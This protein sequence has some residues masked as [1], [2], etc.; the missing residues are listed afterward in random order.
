MV[1]LDVLAVAALAGWVYLA[2]GHGGFWRTGPEP[3]EG[4]EPDGWPDVVAVVPARDEAAILPETLPTL[5][6]QAY[7]G[8]F[9]VVLVD[10][11][12][13][14][15]TA[16]TARRLGAGAAVRLDVVRAAERPDGW[17][18]KVW[19]MREGV[20]AA[21]GPEF[22]LF[23]DADI[24]YAPGT[25]ERLVRAAAGD[26]R[27]LVSRMATLGTRT[28]WERALV[29]AFVYFFALLYP[30]RRVGRPGARTAAAAGGCML[31]RRAVLERAGGLAAIRGALIDDVALGRLIKR[32]GGRCRLDL[33]H[34]VVSRRRYPRPADLWAMVARSAY[35][36]LRYSPALLAGTVLGLLLLFA[37]PPAAAAAGVLAG[38]PAAIVLGS[39]AWA[40]MAGTYAPMLRH[41]GLS[42]LRAPALPLVALAYAAMTVD[43]ARRH[44]TGRGGVWKGRVAVRTR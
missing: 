33:D 1:V 18:G 3:P 10:D 9:R 34:D 36:Q 41:H 5:L 8:R 29:P 27:D 35:D 15:G 19:A 43:S 16:D 32:A 40:V 6:T 30:F 38:D 12:S 7:P 17:A 28:P 42:P 4:D 22:V 39:A 11:G 31:V 13:G 14:D 2:A 20:R 44:H 37:V 26:G 25:V 21:G 24:A 23:T